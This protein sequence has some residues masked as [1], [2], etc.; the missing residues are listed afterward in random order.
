VPVGR[1]EWQGPALRPADRQL[2][3]DLGHQLGGVVHAAA[4]LDRVREAQHRLVLAREE[5]RRRLRRDLHD[6]LGPQLAGLGLRVDTLRNRLADAGV[7]ADAA[8]LDLRA[9]IQ[10][11]VVDVRRIV[12]GLR[13]PALDELGLTGA[14]EQMVERAAGD[15]DVRLDVQ[16]PPPVPAAVE[17]A[18]FRI[19]QEAVTNAVRHSGARSLRVLV[20][21]QGA[22]VCAE[23]ADDGC[24]TPVPRDGGIGLSSMRERAEQIGGSLHVDGAPGAGTRVRVWLPGTG[25]SGA[26]ASVAVR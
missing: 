21:P 22:G 3:E 1:L 20:R 23:I 26:G 5:E 14:L 4:L 13:P 16:A 12:E 11:T 6:G 18:L 2:L 25:T 7:D 9:E 15:L 8:L 17:V 24:G 19:A 10:A